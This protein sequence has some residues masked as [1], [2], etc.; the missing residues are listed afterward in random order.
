MNLHF[1]VC[2]G[3]LSLLALLWLA[4]RYSLFLPARD[5]LPILLYHKVSSNHEDLLTI[6]T[7]RFDRQLAYLALQGY[8]AISFV[9]LKEFVAGRRALP[10]KPIIITF[11]DGYLSTYELAYPLLAK[12]GFVATVF[13]PTA[14]I[15]GGPSWPGASD[16]LMSWEIVAK[17]ARIQPPGNTSPRPFIEFGM[18][19]H[20]HETYVPYTAAQIEADLSDCLRTCLLYTSPSPRDA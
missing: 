18:H 16:P 13:L 3:V 19:S 12:R 1:A 15:G 10:A 20:R 2:A 4:Y 5:G 17:L 9:D 8:T 11:D 14:A 6:S 7:D